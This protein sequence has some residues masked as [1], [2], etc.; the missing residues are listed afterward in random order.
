M[1]VEAE[2]DWVGAR[3]A[4]SVDSAFQWLCLKAQG[5]LEQ[6]NAQLGLAV[7]KFES[8]YDQGDLIV[9]RKTPKTHQVYRFHATENGVAFIDDIAK[10]TILQSTLT[11]CDD[12]QCRLKIADREC[13]FW[14]FRRRALESCFFLGKHER[15]VQ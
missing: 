13:E 2:F 9:F 12:G 8:Q 7:Y 6:R 15:S 1:V 10:R 4:C 11:L 3:A 14:Q 5:D